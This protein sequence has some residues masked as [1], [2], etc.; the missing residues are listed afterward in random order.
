MWWEKWSIVTLKI[1]SPINQQTKH[2]GFVSLH[3][4][5]RLIPGIASRCVWTSCFDRARRAD[6]RRI[7][8][9]R[10]CRADVRPACRGMARLADPCRRTCFVK[11]GTRTCLHMRDGMCSFSNRWQRSGD[12]REKT[13][14]GGERKGGRKRLVFPTSLLVFM[15][16]AFYLP[17][18]SAWGPKRGKPLLLFVSGQWFDTVSAS[19]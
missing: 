19:A 14:D 15:T 6:E 3:P 18:T 12:W 11:V 16:F 1:Q 2:F 8:L 7:W 13:E 17:L 4:A 9:R 10:A 5:R